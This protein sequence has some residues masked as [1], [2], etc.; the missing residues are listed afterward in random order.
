MQAIYLT[1]HKILCNGYVTKN[2][3]YKIKS[4]I[5]NTILCDGYVIDNLVLFDGHLIKEKK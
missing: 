3:L 5:F 1:G 2:L 4:L